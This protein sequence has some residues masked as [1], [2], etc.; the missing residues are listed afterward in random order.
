MTPLE[1]L[2]AGQI[3]EFNKRRTS[4]G[5]LDLFAADLANLNL[6]GA[7]L[8]RANLEK[9]DLS[10]SD[11]TGANLAAANL[12]GADLT[13][14]VLDKVVGVKARLREAYLGEARAVGAEF[15]GADFSEAELT[16]LHA[17]KVRLANARLKSAVLTNAMLA[18]ADLTEARLSEADLQGADFT[19]AVLRAAEMNRVNALSARFERADLS[20]ARI[21]G[22]Q[23]RSCNFTKAKLV[24][25]DLSG[26]DLV[27][28]VL[29]GA[30]LDRADLYEVTADPGVLTPPTPPA[31]AADALE[32]VD[33]EIE[34]HFEDVAVAVS[35]G[36]YAVLWENPDGE[37]VMSLRLM[38]C[39]H[40][41]ENV[42]RSVVVPA[43]ADQVVARFLVPTATGFAVILLLE[44]PGGTDVSWLPV[45]REGVVGT[46]WST[47]AGYTPVVRP[48]VVPDGEGALVYGM[49]RQG[50]L[51]VHR[52]AA[53]TWTE[54]NRAP[55][56]T[57]RGFCGKN[58]PVLLGKGGTV[59]PVRAEGIGKLVT[60][61]TGYPGRLTAAAL[62]PDG[63]RMALAWTA[64]EE[65]GVRFCVA[66]S[67][68]EA[69]RVDPKAS[70]GALDLR[71]VGDRW[72][73][74]YTRE[75]DVSEPVGIWQ[76]GGKPLL[77]A[78]PKLL[79]E[80][81]DVRFVLGEGPPRVA[82]CG[83]GGQ[84]LVVEV[85]D[86]HARP[87]ARFGLFD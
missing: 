40:D 2:Q 79:D 3:Q 35:G 76:P 56:T 28:S 67:G 55:A 66:G 46:A 21:A 54:V 26:S 43:Q 24:E 44:K 64:R 69:V 84:M 41:G 48:V 4:R 16:G 33:G 1:L 36:V 80:A 12:A 5:T 19:G 20:N 30:Q 38:V 74:V 62:T 49:G 73:C 63:E 7:D 31:A 51:T 58:D 50:V 85:E 34:L 60:A 70:V 78:D 61:P 72:L 47:R 37:D 75:V 71:A 25:A 9:A 68:A 87:V 27:G 17:P 42:D 65:K 52:L 82:V 15:S 11:L 32:D 10:G 83:L 29:D 53:G 77:L 39:P 13:N 45:D 8:S 22:A 86:S 18:D 81:E 23:L 6:R 57:W 59:A 14:A